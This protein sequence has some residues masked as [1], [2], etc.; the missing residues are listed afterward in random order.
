[1]A[2]TTAAE[3][4]AAE[5]PI[6]QTG[7]VFQAA[8]LA[9][10]QKRLLFVCVLDEGAAL[11]PAHRKQLSDALSNAQVNALLAAHCICVRLIS[12]TD[13]EHAFTRLFPAAQALSICIAHSAGNA[14]VCGPN[15]TRA[16]IV[17]EIQAQ[18]H[19]STRSRSMS[20]AHMG[21]LEAIDNERLRR[22]LVSRRRGEMQR[23]K[24]AV[25]DFKD[26]RRGYE[27]VH[28]PSSATALSAKRV[29]ELAEGRARLLLRVSN[30]GTAV[31]EFDA[32]EVFSEVRAHVER[33]LGKAVI[34]T[35]APRRVLTDEDDVR[36]LVDLGLAPT[37]T[38]L[39]GVAA[40]PQ[41]QVK[42]T[43]EEPWFEWPAPQLLRQLVYL[44]I[45]G[46][47]LAA[48]VIPNKW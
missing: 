42:K 37:A 25:S 38:L 14:V 29:K 40:L 6:W 28:G 3:I 48:Y 34:A 16:R 32:K 35:T 45:V 19:E 5:E 12:S 17:S 18:L 23:V 26:D 30:G 9:R 11:G 31:V 8:G 46:M 27:Y 24:Q 22:L 21:S 20:A 10:A 44:G 36:S 47:L 2:E 4:T 43:A 41:T 33:E 13:E 15:I 39:I 1:M 7:G